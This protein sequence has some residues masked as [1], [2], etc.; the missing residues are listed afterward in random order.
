MNTLR[1]EI[2]VKIAETEYKSTVNMNALRL[3]C[4]AEKLSLQEIDKFATER[5]LDFVP[6]VLWH[7]IVSRCH[8]NDEPVPEIKFEKFCAHICNDAEQFAELSN[9]ISA[10]LDGGDEGK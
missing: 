7:G 5:P 10:A 6:S 1:G 9:T 3:M 8:F 2:T 4:Q